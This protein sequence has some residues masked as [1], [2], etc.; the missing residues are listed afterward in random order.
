MSKGQGSKVLDTLRESLDDGQPAGKKQEMD[1]SAGKGRYPPQKWKCRIIWT[2]RL[3]MVW[4][5][6]Q[7]SLGWHQ[8]PDVKT[9]FSGG[10]RLQPGE[11]GCISAGFAHV[12]QLAPRSYVVKY[13]SDVTRN[14]RSTRIYSHERMFDSLWN[15]HELLDITRL[16]IPLLPIDSRPKTLQSAPN[17]AS[18][19]LM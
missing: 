14:P 11:K 13:R 1:R 12:S 9:L 16:C 5:Q 19:D 10:F 6:L 15:L 8:P 4:C 7:Q 2:P 3:T 17:L 18:E